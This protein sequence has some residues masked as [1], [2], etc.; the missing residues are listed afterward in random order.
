[1]REAL[2][3]H[4]MAALQERPLRQPRV[5]VLDRAVPD[6]MVHLCGR[7]LLILLSQKGKFWECWLGH[8][9]SLN[10]RRTSAGLAAFAR[11]SSS[12]TRT[13]VSRR[14]GTYAL[15]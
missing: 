11:F 5:R 4:A 7:A 15:H 14:I 10:A 2:R 9:S 12:S 3:H 13:S 6:L 8:H 1:M